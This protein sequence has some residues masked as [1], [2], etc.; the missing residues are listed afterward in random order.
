[1]GDLRVWMSFV[2]VFLA[3]LPWLALIILGGVGALRKRADNHV[4][5]KS[6]L[7]SVD[8][9]SV[10]LPIH[11]ATLSVFKRKI[12]EICS[13]L[14]N[15]R[16]SELIIVFDGCDPSS[17]KEY[18]FSLDQAFLPS[19]LS[20][21]VIETERVG[22]SG[23]QNI[24]VSA[25]TQPWLFLNDCDTEISRGTLESFVYEVWAE[26]VGIVSCSM[27]FALSRQDLRKVFGV[28][29]YWKFENGFRSLLTALGVLLTS[30][31][32]GMFI[33]RSLWPSKGLAL[34]FGDDCA[35]PLI[36][37]RQRYKVVHRDD[38]L[39]HDQPY[40]TPEREYDARVR[41]AERN[42]AASFIESMPWIMM[43]PRLLCSLLVHRL[44]RW[45]SPTFLVAGIFAW[46]VMA[47]LTASTDT[48][49]IFLQTLGLAFFVVTVVVL[50]RRSQ[51]L[52]PL[53]YLVATLHG[54]LRALS[55]SV[56]SEY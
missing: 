15:I 43:R 6:E 22:K 45:F 2:F 20:I 14:R 38:L 30:A 31:G 53:T 39:I 42:L 35:L 25:A 11:N 12:A 41:M 50:S 32:P 13:E 7:G 18:R 52:G 24:G 44:L 49:S 21:T 28:S 3:T 1:M 23:A 34:N 19:S 27:D 55:G 36:V 40:S 8:G 54:S 51:F 17:I 4:S 46:S 26:D 56:R 37:A 16:T 10:I 5:V 48:F 9:L 47:T 33:R 29:L